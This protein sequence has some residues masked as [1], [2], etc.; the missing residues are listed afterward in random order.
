MEQKQEPDQKIPGPPTHRLA[1]A[2]DS[3]VTCYSRLRAR[4]HT[5]TYAD[6][7]SNTC[8]HVHV[9]AHICTHNAHIFTYKFW[10]YFSPSRQLDGGSF[11]D[12]SDHKYHLRCLLKQYSQT[13]S[14]GILGWGQRTQT[15]NNHTLSYWEL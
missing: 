13:L 12:L 1:P 5:H 9:H 8:T 10:K 4:A 3:K 15:S 7:L 2:H 14:L 6:T 11:P